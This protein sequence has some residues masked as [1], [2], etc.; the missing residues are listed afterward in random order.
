VRE[1]QK[2]APPAPKEQKRSHG[3]VFRVLEAHQKKL[4][5]ELAKAQRSRD[6]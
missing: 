1:N 3:S 6:V 5:K 4:R 2:I